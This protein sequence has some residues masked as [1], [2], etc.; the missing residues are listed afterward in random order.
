MPVLGT[1]AFSTAGDVFSLTRS[2]LN[3]ADI[4]NVLTITAIGAVRS[5]NLVTITTAAA[6]GLQSGDKV[7]VASVTDTTF[8]GTQVVVGVPTS[9]TFTYNQTGANASSGNGVVSVLVQGDWATDAVLVPF[10][11]AAYRKLQRRMWGAGSK[12]SSA[13]VIIP[14]VPANTQQLSDTSTPQLPVDFLAPRELFE[15]VASSGTGLIGFVPV[16]Q[17]DVL[18]NTPQSGYNGVYSWWDET[19]NFVGATSIIDLRLRYFV[20]FA[21][22]SDA[23]SVITVR[24]AADTIACW[25]AF[26]A[27]VS[28]GSSNAL[29]LAKMFEDEMKEFLSMQVHARQYIVSRR[30]PANRRGRGAFGS[31]TF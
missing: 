11:N 23:S 7:Q 13:E 8:N 4:P 30:K 17:V 24:G 27:A 6:H 10:A 18:P 12:S 28:R 25:T 29:S 20:G 9:T 14:N 31:A 2:L 21:A 5:G 26:L 15:R 19:L 22:I 3:D 16:R 1:T